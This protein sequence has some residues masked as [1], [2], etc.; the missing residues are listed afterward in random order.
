MWIHL[1][2]GLSVCISVHVP[3]FFS[4]FSERMLSLCFRGGTAVEQALELLV[5]LNGETLKKEV[6]KLFFQVSTLRNSNCVVR[7]SVI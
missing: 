4:F 6:P 3:F 5:C 7:T 2:L 1:T